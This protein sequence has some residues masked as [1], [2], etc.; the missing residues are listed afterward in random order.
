MHDVLSWD[1][2]TLIIQ[3]AHEKIGVVD[4]QW[5]VHQSVPSLGNQGKSDNGRPPWEGVRQY[6]LVL[7]YSIRPKILV[8]LALRFY[9]YIQIND[10]ESK[11]IYN[12]YIKYYRNLLKY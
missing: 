12:T 6:L 2:F 9:V 3:P 7:C 8:V 5:I 1:S 4:A 10:N 11:H